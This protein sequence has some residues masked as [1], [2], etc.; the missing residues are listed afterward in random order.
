MA[1]LGYAGAPDFRGYLN[2]LS[3]SRNSQPGDSMAYNALN[4]VGS[5][6]DFRNG[7]GVNEAALRDYTAG[8]TGN[9][10][11][12]QAGYNRYRSYINDRW[13]EWANR[14]ETGGA[15]GD[16][17]YSPFGSTG[18]SNG[19]SSNQQDLDYLNNQSSLY[20]RLLQSLKSTESSG[21]QKLDQSKI[22]AE[23][24]AKLQQERALRDFSVK[25]EDT[26][27]AKQNA[28]GQ[29]DTNARTL[30][31]SMRR[32]IG[33]AAGSGASANL[34]A[35][36]AVAR[37]ASQQRNNVMSGYAANDRDLSTAENDTNVD[38]ESLLQDIANQRKQKEEEFR[39]GL[40]QQEQG[41]VQ[42]QGE[43]AAE[44]A[45]L[46]G[47]N[48]LSAMKPYQD[49][50]FGLQTNIDQ[51][52]AQFATNVSARDLN[53]KTPQLRDYLVDRQAVNATRQS[54]QQQYSPYSAFLQ[55]KEED[56]LA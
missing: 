31:D 20:D 12:D 41:I 34:A 55:R 18:S 50:Y 51:L 15:L 19:S 28:L 45:R 3:Q 11:D 33:M 1:Q 24:K 43:I 8:A 32:I 36:S 40:A 25:R 16:K 37:Q 39:A 47:G 22:E 6:E 23:N 52:P 49:R 9:P 4:F 35:N 13:N 56:K 26:T 2:Y 17:T 42:S 21:L 5:D 53:V 7:G 54:G 30:S 48:T 46:Q 38:F 10:A 27:R 44:R 14:N 29:V